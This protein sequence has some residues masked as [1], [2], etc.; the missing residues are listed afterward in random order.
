MPSTPAETALYR[1]VTWRL[2]PVLFSCYILAYIDRV[3][4]GFAKLAMKTEPWF[5]E[6]VF[7]TGAGLFFVGYFFFEV[8][9]N[10]LLHK[11]GARLW[12][13][14]IMIGWGLVSV[15]MAWSHSASTFHAFRFLLGIAKAGFFPGKA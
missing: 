3:N 6:A 9:G 1:K 5:S 14:R 15:L 11:V 2:I 10:V 7:A 12:I 8:P 13:A 4:V